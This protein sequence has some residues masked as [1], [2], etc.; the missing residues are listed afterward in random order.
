MTERRVVVTGLG[1]LSPLGNSVQEN[2]Q[3]ALLG[4]SGISQISYFDTDNY[5]T[6][7]A[8]SLKD[9]RAEDYLEKKEIRRIDPFIQFGLISANECIKD[10]NINLEDIDLDKIGVSI[11]SGIGG[12]GTI[13]SN[14]LILD[15]SSP[16]KIS[17]FFVPGAIANM[18]SGYTSLKFGFKGPNISIA[19]ACSSASHSIG[20]SFRSI[21]YGDADMMLTGGSEA[22]ITPLGLAGFCAAK[23]L[24]T[25]NEDPKSASRPWDKDRDGFVLGEGAGC[26]MLEE[27]E[28][29]KKRGAEIYAEI[30]G[31][32][33][34]ADAHHIT[35]PPDRG[36]GAS[37]SMANALNDA[38]INHEEINYINAHGTST[39]AGDLAEN[40]AIK[41]IFG[42]RKEKLIVNSTKSMTGHLLGAAGAI[43]A[44]FSL[45]AIKENVSPPTI[46]LDNPDEGCNFNYSAHQASE[47]D[48]K[49]SLSNSFGF[50]GTNASLIFSEFK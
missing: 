16:R 26:L 13:E 1:L 35:S 37:K 29:A 47:L 50:G 7:F 40:N 27:L 30:K 14:K 32:G 21:V 2:W 28:H 34:S 8:G 25:R 49:Y 33:M 39:P 24:S 12:L 22:S 3:N 6:N 44:I 11:G 31:F 20:F 48:I 23:A 18:V 15:N 9:F 36:D 46:N 45:L 38:K 42:N 19:S 5:T 10:S 41:S 4:K 17:P 43:E